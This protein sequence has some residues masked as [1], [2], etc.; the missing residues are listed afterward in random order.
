[1]WPQEAIEVHHLVQTGR[2]VAQLVPN[3]VEKV[4]PNLFENLTRDLLMLGETVLNEPCMEHAK[5]NFTRTFAIQRLEHKVAE[6]AFS[7][8]ILLL[9]EDL[10]VV[11]EGVVDYQHA[12]G[13]FRGLLL[14]AAKFLEESFATLHFEESFD[15]VE[16][17][18]GVEVEE[19]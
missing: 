7:E 11:D 13:L 12:E 6:I 19:H 10:E 3:H 5:H 2:I 15:V 16:D 9:L 8:C 18:V 4:F 1:V 17:D 14:H